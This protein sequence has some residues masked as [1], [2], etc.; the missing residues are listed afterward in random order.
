MGKIGGKGLGLYLLTASL[1]LDA[2]MNMDGTC[3][4]LGVTAL[5]L[6]KLYGVEIMDTSL[7]PMA[8]TIILL[9]IGAPGRNFADREKKFI[10][11]KKK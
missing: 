8:A 1:P 3:V 5:A 4:Y 7:L 11:H 9:S 6:A 2:T 10:V